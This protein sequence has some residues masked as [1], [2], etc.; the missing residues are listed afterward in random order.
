MDRIKVIEIFRLF[1]EKADD[2]KRSRYLKSILENETGLSIEIENKG[3]TTVTL[4]GPDDDA[5]KAFVL[6]FR[7]F[8]QDNERC[9]I[10]N[11]AKIYEDL[12]I[13][14]EMKYDFRNNRNGINKFLNKHSLLK[15]NNENVLLSKIID[16]FFY[17]GLAHANEE[18]KRIYDIWMNNIVVKG[19]FIFEFHTILGTMFRFILFV[20][21]LNKKVIE[22]LLH[23]N[24]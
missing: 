22:L 5:I 4:K 1:N 17:G 24:E 16:V 13:P 10:R 11:V 21:E 23:K 20:E 7:F 15:L 19:I 12:D 18:K 14:G 3:N 6:T 9:S 2:L 8:I